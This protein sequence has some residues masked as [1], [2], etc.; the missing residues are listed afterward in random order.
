MTRQ[1][2]RAFLA[3]VGQGVMVATL[4]YGAAFEL[5]LAQARADDLPERL[6]FGARERLV[7][8][9]QE[10][11]SERIMPM[12][13]EQMRQGTSL[14]ELVAAAALA[15]ARTFGG[16]DYVGFHAF[17][18]LAPAWQM[19]RQLPASQAAL[20]VMKVL[21]RNSNRI[22]EKGGRASEVLRP[23]APAEATG[24]EAGSQIRQAVHARDLA[25]AEQLLASVNAASPG[26]G[27]DAILPSVADAVE[28]HR[29]VL[30]Y[31]A[32][33]LLDLVGREHATTFLRQSLHYCVDN[34]DRYGNRFD[35]LPDLV[36][37]LLDQYRLVEK[38]PG[39]RVA[40]DDWIEATSRHLFAANAEQ[41]ADLAAAALADD[42][43]PESVAEAIALAANQLVLSDPGRSGRS[44]QPNKPQ[45]SVHGDSIGVH[46]S[47][48]INAWRNIAA[49]SNRRNGLV[50]LILAGWQ[51]GNDRGYSPTMLSAPFWPNAERL[52]S[53]RSS[54]AGALLA[55]LNDAIRQ[56]DQAGA[57]A[58]VTRYG[59]LGHDPQAVSNLLLEY[60]INDDGALHAEKYFHTTTEEFARSRAPFRWRHLTGLARVTASAYGQP[61]PGMEQ[62]RELLG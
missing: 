49:V 10:T 60:A 62:A 6:D 47:D 32:W 52:E 8:L 5:G 14:D 33:D 31:R 15:N 17:M 12:L 7:A 50:A 43:A 56:Q 35:G 41:A 26:E 40:D 27:L 13:A 21:Y 23:V 29:T 2:R 42:M 37:R 22:Q 39:S 3:E 1:D 54:D 20:P 57:C 51:V 24:S 55:E 30:A 59:Q 16:E 44:V 53:V 48:S 4:G 25:R 9:M 38:S 34:C 46:A 36:T 61:A 11:S 45:G 19:S 18:A 58:V 28:V